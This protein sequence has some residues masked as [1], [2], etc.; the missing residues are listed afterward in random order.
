MDKIAATY[1]SRLPDNTVPFWDFDD[2]KI[3]NAPRDASAA[4]IVSSAFLQY[5]E[6][7]KGK[8]K[9]FYQDWAIRMLNSL[10]SSYTAERHVP[11]F[12]VRSTGSKRSEIEVSINYANYYYIEALMWLKKQ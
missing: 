1:L 8:E 10:V 11:A 7:L 5:A 6:L 12:L 4:A 2:P 9:R 3:P